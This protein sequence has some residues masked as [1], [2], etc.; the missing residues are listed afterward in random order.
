MALRVV[1]ADDHP[2]FLRA[3]QVALEREG[4]EIVGL[5]RSAREAL[6]VVDRVE[7]DVVL[8]DVGMPGMDGVE[9]LA[10]LRRF[11]KVKVV[12]LSA[13]RDEQTIDR[14]LDAGALCFVEKSVEPAGIAQVLRTVC[15]DVQIRYKRR[16]V[17]SERAAAPPG[18]S[19]PAELLTQRERE[20]LS[21]VAKGGSNNEIARSLWVTEQTVK[22]HLSNIYRKL[23]VRNRT[24]AARR[25]WELGLIEPIDPL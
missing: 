16:G 23:D 10:E 6:D 5:A 9:C 2:L 7:P 21:T 22:F 24:Q 8:L 25:G 13:S 14:C 15:G 11:A 1:L 20:I 17:V 12:M 3:L 4:L 19:S 18:H